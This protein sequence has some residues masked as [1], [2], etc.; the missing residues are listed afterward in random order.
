MRSKVRNCKTPPSLPTTSHLHSWLLCLLPREWWS[1]HNSCWGLCCSCPLLQP[2]SSSWAT[3]LLD[4]PQAQVPTGKCLLAGVD[5]SWGCQESQLWH[6]QYLLTLLLLSTWCSGDCCPLLTPSSSACVI[7]FAPP[8]ILF[9]RGV[10]VWQ[11]D[12]AVP[13][14]A[15]AALA[16]PR[17]GSC[18]PCCQHLDNYTRCNDWQKWLLKMTEKGVGCITCL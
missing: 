1:V 17:Q 6:L 16:C 15:L 8:Q 11:P 13:C 9:P 2:G 18:R 4:K 14:G 5:S 10:P 7:F 12:W 3:V